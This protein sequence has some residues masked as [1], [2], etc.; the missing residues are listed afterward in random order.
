LILKQ[1]LNFYVLVLPDFL[2]GIK[3]SI[4]TNQ[5][6]SGKITE[7]NETLFPEDLS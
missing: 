2:G 5:Q 4:T 6:I 7:M 3:Q 1:D